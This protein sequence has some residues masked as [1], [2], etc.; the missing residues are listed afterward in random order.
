MLENIEYRFSRWAYRDDSE[1]LTGDVYKNR[2]KVLSNASFLT[3]GQCRHASADFVISLDSL[4]H[5]ADPSGAL[6]LMYD[7]L[8]PAARCKCLLGHLGCIS[9]ED[10]A[11]PFPHGRASYSAG[12]HYAVGIVR[13]GTQRFRTSKK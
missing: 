3:P 13:R 10:I 6:N 1:P 5:F 4:E 12:M 11:A 7:L 2:S 8:A 9:L